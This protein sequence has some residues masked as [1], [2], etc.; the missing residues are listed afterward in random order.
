M[1]TRL[2]WMHA[3]SARIILKWNGKLSFP[4]QWGGHATLLD[5]VWNCGHNNPPRQS[6]LYNIKTGLLTSMSPPLPRQE[7]YSQ[8]PHW[9]WYK[10]DSH[11]REGQCHT[12]LHPRGSCGHATPLR[13][14]LLDKYQWQE[15][16]SSSGSYWSSMTLSQMQDLGSYQVARLSCEKID[17]TIWS[18]PEIIT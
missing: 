6:Q 3:I 12:L 10:L 1:T 2:N 8:E 17:L 13:F 16:E 14:Y 4:T 18:L 5:P 15:E 7:V 11:S 9:T